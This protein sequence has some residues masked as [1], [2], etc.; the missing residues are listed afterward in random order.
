MCGRIAK[1]QTVCNDTASLC[2]PVF[3][4]EMSGLFFCKIFQESKL[5]FIFAFES[6]NDFNLV[7]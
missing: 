1:M 6:L 2:N 7:I 3:Y 4:G 5:F